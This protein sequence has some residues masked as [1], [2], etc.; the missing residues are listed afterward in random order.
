MSVRVLHYIPGRLRLRVDAV[1]RSPEFAARVEREM[2]E[3]PG[4]RRVEARASTGSVMLEYDRT[5]LRAPE[6]QDRLRGALGR[7]LPPGDL[8]KLEDYLHRLM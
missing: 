5:A 1:K 3:V 4:V 8:A 2:A 6:T 7:L